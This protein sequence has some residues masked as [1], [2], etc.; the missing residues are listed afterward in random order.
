MDG[1]DERMQHMPKKPEEEEEPF[2]W[3]TCKKTGRPHNMDH[4]ELE[5]KKC[6]KVKVTREMGRDWWLVTD[7]RGIEGW[8]HASWLDFK[9]RRPHADA[10]EAYKHFKEDLDKVLVP[11]QLSAFPTMAGYVEACTK[12]QCQQL[13]QD[14]AQLG[15]CVHDLAVLLEGSGSLSH[16]WLKAERNVWHPDR[17]ARFCHPEHTDRLK[18][19]AEQMFVMYGVIMANLE[20]HGV[21]T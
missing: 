13:K 12:P 1:S 6:E 8:V 16:D 15:I 9:N 18:V 5:L 11:G 4:W 20:R 21:T 17:F 2:I 10:K 3:A 14:A 19:L 7:R